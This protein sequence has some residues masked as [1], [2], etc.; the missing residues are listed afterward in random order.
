MDSFALQP[1]PRRFSPQAIPI[2]PNFGFSPATP[3]FPSPIRPIGPLPSKGTFPSRIPRPK[4]TAVA[5]STVSTVDP[6]SSLLPVDP[7]PCRDPGPRDSPVSTAHLADRPPYLDEDLLAL[8]TTFIQRQQCIPKAELPSRPCP[9]CHIPTVLGTRAFF[10]VIESTHGK[11]FTTL[12][13]KYGIADDEDLRLLLDMHSSRNIRLTGMFDE[14]KVDRIQQKR[15]WAQLMDIS[16][17][18][19]PQAVGFPCDQVFFG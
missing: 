16:N 4:K 11:L 5:V 18:A 15:F 7:S 13:Y 8:Q 9:E 6:F 1:K 17:F 2:A 14:N 10:A 19:R 12:L 3:P